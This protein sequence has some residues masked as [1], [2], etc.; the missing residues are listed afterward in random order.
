MVPLRPAGG[1]PR[2]KTAWHE[3]TGGV[4][5]RLRRHITRPGKVV[6]R[7]QQRRLVAVVGDSE[8]RQQRLWLEARRQGI[9]HAP[10]VVWLSDGAR[11]LWHLCEARFAPHA[12][13]I[14]DFYHAAQQ[15]WKGAAAWL[16]GRTTQARR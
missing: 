5:A 13:G 15:R 6:A 14:L 11:G 1:S 16:D 12:T 9:L 8:A 10:Q 4:L 2:G 7:L 3:I